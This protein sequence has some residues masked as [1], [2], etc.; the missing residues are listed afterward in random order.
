[1]MTPAETT[2]MKAFAKSMSLKDLKWQIANAKKCNMPA[3]ATKIFKEE[4]EAR[5]IRSELTP[6][7]A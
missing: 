2:G 3:E 4:L 7:S 6:R 5:L 1:M